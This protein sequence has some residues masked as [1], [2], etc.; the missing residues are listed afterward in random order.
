MAGCLAKRP[1][2]NTKDPYRERR[3]ELV[4]ELASD[5]YLKDLKAK[6]AMLNVKRE[7]FVP[8]Q[9]RV[10]AYEDNPLPTPDQSTISAP[11]MHAIYLSAAQMKPGDSVL[12][13]GFGSG[14]LLAYSYEIVG[15]KGRVVGIEISPD[16]YIFGKEN[17]ERAGYDDKVELILGDIDKVG[18]RKFDKIFVSATAPSVP[19]PLIGLLKEGGL[20]IVPVVESFGG[21]ELVMIK[22]SKS[23]KVEQKNLGGVMFVP[24]RGEFGFKPP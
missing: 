7:D 4:G 21:Q 1:S 19:K 18:G 17:L 24:L 22:K 5:G 15:P 6:N 20:M 2:S 11:H 9:F 14:I 23:G 8:A 16:V 3:A 12:E 10:R 13:I